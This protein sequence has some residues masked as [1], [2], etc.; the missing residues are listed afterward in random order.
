MLRV[1]Q[2]M[3]VAPA[4]PVLGHQPAQVLRGRPAPLSGH[5][6]LRRGALRIASCAVRIDLKEVPRMVP[7]PFA[8]TQRFT[9]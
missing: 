4:A 3:L 5:G 9:P 8:A 6:E 1:G 7:T 2:G